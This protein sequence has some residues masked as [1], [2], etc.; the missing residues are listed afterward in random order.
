MHLRI[1]LKTR[2]AKGLLLLV[3]VSLILFNGLQAIASPSG[4]TIIFIANETKQPSSATKIN[5]TGG[6][7]TTVYLNATTQNNRWKAYVGNVT[8]TM[9]LDD[10]NDNTLFDWTLSEVNGEIYATRFSGSINWSG[11]NC[12]NTTHIE[13]E[14]IAL[15]HTNK[16]D[17]LTTTFS[18]TLH[19]QFYVGTRQI[20]ADTCR[21]VHTYVNNTAQ[22][23]RFEELVLY[24]G[25]NSTNGNIV[26]ATPL[27]RDQYGF[28]QGIY[29]FQMI[30]PEV[31]L[32]DWTSSTAY[33]FYAELT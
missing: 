15:N 12:S 26:Y 14:N 24:D 19:Q 33:Y 27:E 6:S 29:D 5:T 1:R 2:N 8:G 30:V 13:L 31:G 23:S 16:D 4:P 21:S 22:S 9:T 17:N 7:I 28:D 3:V 10:G 20:L 11:I 18:S 25:T 32:S